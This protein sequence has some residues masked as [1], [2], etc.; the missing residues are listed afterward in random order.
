MCEREKEEGE[1]A[2]D[3]KKN[4]EYAFFCFVC[5]LLLFFLC[6]GTI[7]R[8]T[9][10]A[11][12]CGGVAAALPVHSCGLRP[13]QLHSQGLEGEEAVIFTLAQ[14]HTLDTTHTHTLTHSPPPSSRTG[15]QWHADAGAARGIDSG[16][17]QREHG[18][19]AQVPAPARVVA[20]SGARSAPRLR[21][22]AFM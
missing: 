6:C 19:S 18:G 15:A 13:A 5:P 12:V 2:K 3:K 9:Q 7:P 22:M 8:R 20:N 1:K 11:G 17:S 4:G 16:V 14:V 10:A 21:R